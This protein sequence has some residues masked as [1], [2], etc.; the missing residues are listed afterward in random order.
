LT[1]SNPETADVLYKLDA[2]TSMEVRTRIEKWL[3]KAVI[4]LNLCPFARAPIRRGL[5]RFAVTAASDADALLMELERE[6]LLLAAID[7]AQLETV[8]LIHPMVMDE[9]L[10]FHFFLAEAE[11]LMRRLELGGVLQ[12]ASFHPRYQFAASQENDIGNY[13]NR[14]PYPILHLLREDSVTRAAATLADA[15]VVSD[16]NIDTLTLLGHEGWHKL[17]TSAT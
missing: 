3:E 4:G 9:F 2:A 10:D 6:A 1:Q 5:V 8:L 17:W 14:S 13:T 11:A 12:I 7:A 16:R 15:S